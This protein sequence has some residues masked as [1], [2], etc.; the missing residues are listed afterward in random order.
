MFRH[1]PSPRV[2]LPA[3]PLLVGAG[4]LWSLLWLPR[5]LQGRWHF[6]VL[7]EGHGGSSQVGLLLDAAPWLAEPQRLEAAT[8]RTRLSLLIRADDAQR[9]PAGVRELADAGHELVLRAASG[10]AIARQRRALEDC[11]GTAVTLVLPAAYW[12]WTL[13]HLRRAGL[14][15][16]QPGLSGPLPALLEETEPGGLLNLSS[17][18]SPE[19]SSLLATLGER[20]YKP[21]P[22]GALEGLRTETLRGLLQRIYRRVFDQAFDRQHHILKLT[23]RARALF[24]ISRRPYDGPVLQGERTYLPGTPAA[25]LHIHSKRL[26]ALAERS[27]LTGLRAV[28]SSL[29]DV[30]KVLDEQEAYQDV[31]IVYALTIFAEVL[32]PLG[33]HSQPLDNPRTARIMAFFM[34]L[35]RVL[36]GAKNTDRRVILPQIIWMT[37]QELLTRYTRPARKVAAKK[38]AEQ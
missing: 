31:Q 20:D 32:T 36:Y 24:R 18:E 26:V 37:R 8:G 12:P 17:L 2:R 29:Y 25:E 30:A 9:F 14:R 11:A 38:T 16:V 28:Q 19:L 22:L 1:R 33:F 7:R 15:A 34:N 23:Q 3:A 13:R 4:A 21:S 6:G 35:L 10:Q 27:A 5:L